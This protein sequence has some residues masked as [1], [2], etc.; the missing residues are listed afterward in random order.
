MDAMAGETATGA[1]ASFGEYGLAGLVILALFFLVYKF[2]TRWFD[3][4]VVREE[5]DAENRKHMYEAFN[6][7]TKAMDHNTEVSE[8]HIQAMKQLADAVGRLPCTHRDPL[9][10]TRAGDLREAESA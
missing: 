4:S 3:S 10:R 1:L 7:L 2:G 6:G 9:M 5:R 8:R